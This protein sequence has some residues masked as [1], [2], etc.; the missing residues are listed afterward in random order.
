MH[1]LTVRIAPNHSHTLANYMTINIVLMRDG[2]RLRYYHIIF[3]SVDYLGG[4]CEY[5]DALGDALAISKSLFLRHKDIPIDPVMDFFTEE[6]ERVYAL[7][8][9]DPYE[10]C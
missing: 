1:T 5:I 6:W 4:T 2:K 8:S 10:P 7:H 9:P 3:P